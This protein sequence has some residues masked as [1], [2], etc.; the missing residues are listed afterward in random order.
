MTLTRNHAPLSGKPPGTVNYSID[1]P[2]HRL[3]L[4]DFPRRVRAELAGETVL[5]TTRAALLHETG[6][7]PQLYIP[8]EDVRRDLLTPT[9]HHT[10]CPFKGE[11]SYWSVRA[12]ERV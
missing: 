10:T 11:A 7:I 9:D 6:L 8:E 3:L 4:E 12:G 2:A 1:G 5:D